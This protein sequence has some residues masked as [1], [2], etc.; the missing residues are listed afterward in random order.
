MTYN[1][2]IINGINYLITPEDTTVQTLERSNTTKFT[3][4]SAILMGVVK[5][6]LW[7]AIAVII[8]VVLL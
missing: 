7:S 3:G 4:L 1:K 6:F 8:P 5:T 2:S